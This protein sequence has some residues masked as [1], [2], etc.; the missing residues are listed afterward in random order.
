MAIQSAVDQS[1][2]N[3]EILVIDDGSG[4]DFS[5]RLLKW[6]QLDS[7]IVVTLNEQNSGAYTSRNLGFKAAQG[8]YLTVFDGDDWQHP[9]KIEKLVAASETADNSRLVS[10]PWSR[11]DEDLFF[12]YR[13]WRGL[14]VTP[15]H[16]STMFATAALREKTGYWD[17]VRKAADTEYILRYQMMV[18]ADEPISATLAPM[19]LSLVGENNLSM[20]DFRLGYRSPDRISYRA[21]YEHWHRSIA[22]G[23]VTGYMDFPLGER[24]FPAPRRFLP[25]RGGELSLDLVL[26]GDFSKSKTPNPD[27]TQHLA[28]ALDSNMRVGVCQMK[29]PLTASS[30]S[31]AFPDELM[32][33]IANREITRVQL[34]DALSAKT[35]IAYEPTTYQFVTAAVSGI[36]ADNLYVHAGEAP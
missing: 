28:Q 12:Q 15:S 8:K 33:L 26:V 9:Q 36:T 16:V 24:N 34:T 1:Y 14:F 17:S 23:R 30:V 27:L 25:H 11:V 21:S 29:S 2:E 5:S 7:R 35:V 10:A 13:G 6:E 18:N 19:T 32:D 4:P 3:I 20:E 31:A 22:D